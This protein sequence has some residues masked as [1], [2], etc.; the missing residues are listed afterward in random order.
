LAVREALTYRGEALRAV[1]LPLGGIGTGSMALAGDGGLRQWQ[2]VN[3][4]NHDAHV[5]DSFFAIWAG[6]R[7]DPGR[8]AVVLQSDALYNDSGFQPAPSVSDH[9][10]PE[11]SRR[12]LAELPGVDSLEISA[13]YPI[14]EVAYESRAIPVQVHLEA[15]SPFIPLNSRDSGLPAVLFN[16]TVTNPGDQAVPV[17]LMATQQNLV[18][19]DGKTHIVGVRNPGYGG[20]VNS[21]VHLQGVT[22]LDMGNVS[23]PADH[24]ANGRL[25]LA[26][27]KRPGD[28]TTAMIQWESP[29]Q[30]WDHF[31]TRF[32]RLPTSEAY[33]ASSGVSPDG[34]TWNGALAV[35]FEL[36]PGASR[37]VT[38][39]LA[40]YFPNRY[41]TW[42]QR[43]M[44][45]QNR[46]SHFWLGN[47][48]NNW[49]GS[50]LAVVE[51]VR[52]NY[53]RLVEQTRL[54]RDCFFD[55]TLPWQLLES[56]AGPVSTIRTP[57]CLWNE[58]GRFHGF[59]GCHGASTTHG[60]LEGCC[61]M[62]CTHV[63]NYEMALA[64]LFPDLEQSMRCTDLIDQMSPWGA[65]PHRTPLPL[66]LRRPW[67]EFIGGPRNPAMDGE[68]G[69]VLKTYR[70]V[71]HGACQEWFNEMWPRV[72]KLMQHI[73]DDYDTE[74]DGV[75]RGEQP[76]TYD[77]SIYGPNTFI[78][79]LYL[80]ALRA[81]EEM[82]RLQGESDLAQLY[83]ERFEL[84]S[85]KYDELCWNGEYYIQIVDLEQYPEQQFGTGCHIDQLLGQWW[86]HAL[87][88][89]YV[90][91][92]EHVKTAVQNIFKF[93]RREGFN[94]ADQRPRIYMDE[95]DKG[96]Y[97]CTW[98]HG[99]K[100]EVPTLYSDEVW[101]GLEYPLACLL[102]FEGEIEPALTML[103]DIR[104]R[105]DGTRRSPWN[106]VECGDHYVRPMASWALLEAAAG[107]QYNAPRGRLTFAPRISPDDFRGFFIAGSGWGTFSQQGGTARLSVDYGS[108]SL[109][110]LRLKGSAANAIVCL[111]EQ[112]I[113]ADVEQ[114]DGYMRLRFAQ[115]VTIAAGEMLTVSFG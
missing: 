20:N 90:L 115:P 81:A 42:D 45:V 83:R 105:H 27:L 99:G 55:S 25:A 31:A 12:L 8:N 34:Q 97:I 68:L 26:L 39:V 32:G 86:A 16:F 104:E 5:P 110:E 71:R 75:I 66:Y 65:I 114:I 72:K 37:T 96:L 112:T 21:L 41:V 107:Y 4:V 43:N 38:F 28:E 85:G 23:I 111:G 77:I 6:T 53:S 60:T 1:A 100:P 63:W 113:A 47:Q 35:H 30:L 89:G 57:T 67:D 78:G 69:T 76:N 50:A 84:G 74:S 70:E 9:L 52:D 3:N 49:L 92:K 54:Y 48:Y 13:Q 56:V 108:L 10:I 87:D 7:L 29:R 46:K 40:W 44:G 15:F 91:P 88:L 24:P 2:I 95:R 64:K 102:L 18:G 80:A 73:M 94:K 109:K 79:S 61:P 19:W 101:S 22:A 51:Y 14:V 62:N 82:A 33:P 59:E 11:G 93:N 106:E 58:D 17:S 103:A 36:A 98:P